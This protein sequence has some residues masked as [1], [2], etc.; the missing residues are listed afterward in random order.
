MSIG[1][2]LEAIARFV[3]RGARVADVGT[4]HGYIPVYLVKKGY[5]SFVVASDIN[6]GPLEKA[7]SYVRLNGLEKNIE[8]RLG[9]GLC[10]LIAGEVDEIIIAGMGGVLMA[11]IIEESMGVAKSAKK[12]ILQPM[13]APDE[14][15]RYLLGAGFEITR[16]A[17]VKE[18]GKIYEIMTARYTNNVA[19]ENDEI[20]FEVGKGLLDSSDPLLG[21]FL[22]RK[23]KKYEDIA[24]SIEGIKTQKAQERRE[25]CLLKIERLKELRKRALEGDN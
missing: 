18:D 1:N 13:Q 16:E 4:D 25:Y 5:S 14:L 6:T 11:N 3:D 24:I 17:L 19:G 12:L 9:G 8:T 15:R 2:R 21:E 22:D 10:V 7:V 20:Y 23:I